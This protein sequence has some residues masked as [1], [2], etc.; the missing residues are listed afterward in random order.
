MSAPGAASPTI[1]IANG[2]VAD[3]E[4]DV[5]KLH[6]LPSEQQDLYL[7]AFV[8]DFSRHV[9]K[10]DGERLA[11]HQ[12]SIKSELIKLLELTSPAPSRV[13]RNSLGRIFADVF[14]R[15][16]RGLLYETI[17][18]LLGFI[19]AGKGEKDLANKHAAVVCIGQIFEAVGDSA[20]SLSNLT[21]ASLV[22]LTKQAQNHAGLRGCIARALAS[23]IKGL[24]TSVD[25][26]AARDA[27]KYTRNASTDKSLFVQRHACACLQQLVLST[28]YFDNSNDFESLKATIWK[29]IESPA[30][31]VRHAA[32]GALGAALVKAAKGTSANTAPQIRKPKKTKKVPQDADEEIDAERPGSPSSRKVPIHLS[33]SLPEVLKVL[34]TQYCRPSVISK[35]AR[36]GIAACYKYVLLQLPDTVVEENYGI[37]ANHFFVDLLS[38]PII[39]RNRYRLLLTRKIVGVL[40][41]EVIGT[42]ILSEAA[43]LTAAQ[44]LIDEVLKAF[45]Q[46]AEGRR[47]PSKRALTSALSALRS[48]VSGLGSAFGAMGDSCREALVQIIQHHSYT[49]QIHVADCLR[50]LAFNCPHQLLP[51]VSHCQSKLETELSYLSE[52]RH[53]HRRCVAFATSLAAITSVSRSR[54]LYISVGTT[55]QLFNSATGLL[56]ASSSSELRVS[57]TQIQVA[58]ILIGGLLPLGPNFVK[59]H[60]SQLLL[61]WRNA[62]PMPLARDNVARRGSL[63]SSFLAH[64]RE[65]AL[66]AMFVFFEHNGS[67]LTLDGS[68][69]IAAMLQN[70]IV[71]LESLSNHAQSD[72]V[73]SR[74]FTALD[75]SD[76]ITMVRRRVLQCFAKLISH[77]H[78]EN[79][80]LL[81]QSNV[82][83]LAISSLTE[84]EVLAPRGLETTIANATGNF[85]TLWDTSDN[86]GFG[87]NGLVRGYN[88]ELFPKGRLRETADYHGWAIL[89]QPKLDKFVS[90]LSP[91][92]GA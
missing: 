21:C 2:T 88:I 66:G 79:A 24:G 28:T 65:C 39:S 69:R 67:L 26:Q 60:L 31:P 34:S 37:I 45:P 29:S 30:A 50:A 42:S 70:T 62:L 13:I 20:I 10:I 46:P 18:D 43:Q 55:S 5:T 41:E 64:V 71:F 6:S 56:K 92:F 85:E 17:N 27:W 72:E 86:W 47:E 74:L 7:L 4:L 36:V 91:S 68:K 78:L 83:N 12:A 44:W 3:L 19:N 1:D 40:L 8:S 59:I 15:G 81:S 73:S 33:M 32:A 76:I 14:L 25:E 87:V 89:S 82:V 57:A 38:H 35:R 75:L 53:S 48:L 22:R 16:S 51:C 54:P 9:R 77:H 52:P 11:A 90:H 58:W 23:I 84:T 80:D 63:E 49:V 61:L